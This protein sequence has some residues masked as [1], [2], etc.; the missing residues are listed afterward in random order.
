[1]GPQTLYS[2]IMLW[3]KSIPSLH[4][5]PNQV[6]SKRAYRWCMFCRPWSQ[7]RP[8]SGPWWENGQVL[9]QSESRAPSLSTDQ[10]LLLLIIPPFCAVCAKWLNGLG[11]GVRYIRWHST[12]GYGIPAAARAKLQDTGYRRG[13]LRHW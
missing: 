7:Y 4:W 1:M 12:P 3:R 6:K 9:R 8:I 5:R 13:S 2:Y 11:K 10:N